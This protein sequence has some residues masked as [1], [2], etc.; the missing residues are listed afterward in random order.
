MTDSPAEAKARSLDQDQRLPFLAYAGLGLFALVLRII[1]LFQIEHAP[2]AHALLGDAAAYDEWAR[3]IAAGDWI[4]QGVFYQA[5]LY[6]Y[7]LAVV[8][9]FT[10]PGVLTV[11]LV[12]ALSSS[13]A[14][15]LL[16]GAGTRWFNRRTGFAAG[17]L[18]AVYP[19]AIFFDGL[20]QKASLDLLLMCALLLVMSR[21]RPQHPW[22][23]LLVG[24]GTALLALN[25]ENALL[26]APVLM[27]WLAHGV[28]GFGWRRVLRCEAVFLLGLAVVL[29]PVA[30][31]NAV[32]GGEFHL[33]T[34]QFGPN[35]YIG[36]NPEANGSY[37]ALRFARGSPATEQSDATE[38]AEAA[39]GHKL[40]PAGVSAY[41]RDRALQFIREQPRAWLALMGR[42][43]MLLLNGVELTDTEDMYTWTEQSA[44]LS[45]LTPCWHFGFAVPLALAGV[46]LTWPRRGRLW[47]LYLIVLVYA[48]S[49]VVFYV[50]ARYRYPLVPV[51]LLFAAAALTAPWLDLVRSRRYGFMGLAALLAAGTG[52]LANRDLV[53]VEQMRATT[54][55]NFGWHLTEQHE[56][57]AAGEEFALG[58]A[59]EPHYA[60]H[61]QAGIYYNLALSLTR[62]SQVES[63]L[64]LLD[65]AVRL[66]PEDANINSFRQH[67][68]KRLRR[69]SPPAAAP[70]GPAGSP[71]D[72]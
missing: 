41:W 8:Y 40:A 22:H 50:F 12:Q 46:V 42:K 55:L 61:I 71:R 48:L 28:R 70:A 44:L 37:Q 6:P 26:L 27:L 57:G 24:I 66:D 69:I 25:R 4:G 15:M 10:G 68:R 53:S 32:V 72:H 21:A 18:L 58:M 2:L 13:V 56:F 52:L 23:G 20:V 31:R 33:T 67:V 7:L 49:V 39:V 47:P 65:A 3:K 19:P 62:Q 59:C 51:V 45:A 35:F 54:H 29:L 64:K 34:S 36:N 16:A 11:R 9:L 14:C 1:Y 38:L 30:V 5:P 63:A 60:R 43:A 17:L